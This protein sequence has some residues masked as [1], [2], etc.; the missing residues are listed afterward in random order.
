MSYLLVVFLF[1]NIIFGC[2][3]DEVELWGNCYNIEETL[4]LDLSNNG[5]SEEIPSQIGQLSNLIELNLSLNELSGG[6]PVELCNLL[7]L[8]SLNLS[9]NELSSQI[10]AEIGNLI[11]LEYLFLYSNK[12][13]L[14]YVLF[15]TFSKIIFIN[16]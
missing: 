9:N 16:L 12:S 1:L 8:T 6:I 3:D 11:N 10:P 14:A 4:I 13:F 5:L 2:V 15:L 7:N